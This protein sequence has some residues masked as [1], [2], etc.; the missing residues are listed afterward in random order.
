MLILVV[1]DRQA[2]TFRHDLS[3]IISLFHPVLKMYGDAL[4]S[5]PP[6]TKTILKLFEL[7]LELY[8]PFFRIESNYLQLHMLVGL[9]STTNV[10]YSFACLI[11]VNRTFEIYPTRIGV[12]RRADRIVLTFADVAGAATVFP[13]P[14]SPCTHTIHTYPR[15]N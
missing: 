3:K 15:I 12:D 9:Q 13:S 14:R 5:S 8:N 11:R 6:K 10:H 4:E 2:L 1:P 7:R